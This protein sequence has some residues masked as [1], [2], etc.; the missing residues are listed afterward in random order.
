SGSSAEPKAIVATEAQLLA[1]GRHIIEAM[2]ITCD[3]VSLGVIPL[4][5]AYGLGNLVLPLILQGTTIAIRE[6]FAPRLLMRDLTDRG[7]TTLPGV[8]FMFDHVRRHEKELRPLARLRLIVTA[9]APIAIETLQF[10]KTSS[11]QKLHS[12]YGASETGG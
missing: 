8:P 1:D 4:A 7:V 9:G 10:F 5:H 11:G 2:A 3:D 6:T 12:L